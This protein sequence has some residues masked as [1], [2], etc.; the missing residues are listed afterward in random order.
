M[1]QYLEH[2]LEAVV[3]RARHTPPTNYTHPAHMRI[4]V[5]VSN[6]LEG[7]SHHESPSQVRGD[8][9]GEPSAPDG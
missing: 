5:F 3:K 2:T 9:Y 4:T 1:Y 8:M 6:W 7:L